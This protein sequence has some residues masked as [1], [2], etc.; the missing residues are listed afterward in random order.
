MLDKGDD[1]SGNYEKKD[2]EWEIH[3]ISKSRKLMKAKTHKTISVSKKVAEFLSTVPNASELIDGLVL[4]YM[5]A[6]KRAKEEKVS[7]EKILEWTETEERLRE[8]QKKAE[9]QVKDFSDIVET[10][11]PLVSSF[12]KEEKEKFKFYVEKYA[13]YAGML[14]AINEKL[15]EVQA[16]LKRE[17][18]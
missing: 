15:T 11:R 18:T 6:I 8:F 3:V 7:L 4:K 16:K 17:K 12:T 2:E 13:L 10:L 9:E 1:M 5:D 14:E